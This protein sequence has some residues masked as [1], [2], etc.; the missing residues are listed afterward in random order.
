MNPL[1]SNNAK[2]MGANIL[3]A[4]L[5]ELRLELNAADPKSQAYVEL[6]GRYREVL[7]I[8]NR[9]NKSAVTEAFAVT[10]ITVEEAIKMKLTTFETIIVNQN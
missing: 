9:M 8:I 3:Q 2:V 1:L 6:L 7:H 10:V 4:R 5:T